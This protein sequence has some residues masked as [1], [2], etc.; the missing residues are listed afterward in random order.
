VSESTTY[1]VL[2]HRATGGRAPH[3]YQ[4]R[5]ATGTALPSVLLAPTG[6]GKTQAVVVA[7]LYRRLFAEPAVRA[8]TPRR[9]V[10]ALPMRV[11]VEQVW[12]VVNGLLD[13]L[14][15]DEVG[16]HL[17]IGG[18]GRPRDDWARHPERSALLVGTVD[19]LVSRALNRGYAAGRGRWPVDFGLLNADCLWVLDETQLMGAAV[20]TAAQLDGLRAKLGTFSACHTLWMS[21]TVDP[22][23]L[24]TVDRPATGDV[25]TLCAD[26]L[27]GELGRRL[28]APKRME[29]RDG[30]VAAIVAAEHAANS[31]T[32]A[33]HNTV[34]AAT[35]TYARLRRRP[36]AGEPEV[37]LLHSRF[38]P[39][40][41]ERLAARLAEPPPPGGRV[42]CATQ[43][44]E[45]GVDISA[46]LLV[47][48][49]APWSS[50]VQRLGRC[51]RYG[52]H[53]MGLVRWVEPKRPEPY[54]R[55]ELDHARAVL[56]RLEGEDASPQA[57]ADLHVEL[58]PAPLHPTLRRRDLL[59][60]F[61]TAPDLSGG[62][63][64]VSRFI[65][66]VEDVDCRVYWRT[67]DGDAPPPDLDAAR[68]EE[69]CPAPIGELRRF[70]D[71]RHGFTWDAVTSGWRR[72]RAAEL[73]PGAVVLLPAA[74]GGYTSE[75]GWDLA[76]KAPVEPLAGVAGPP[77][78]NRADPDAQIGAWVD[79]A[80]HTR[81]VEAEVGVIGAAALA[82]IPPEVAETLRLAARGHDVGKAFERWQAAVLTGA[83][84]RQG[85]IWAKTANRVA[86]GERN[87]RHELVSALALLRSGWLAER[88]ADPWAD[89][90]LFLVAAHHGKAR[91]TIRPWPDESDGAVLG[92]RDGDRL[93]AVTVDGLSLPN[94][95][96]DLRPLRMGDTDAGA[97]WASR[98]LRLRDHPALGPFRVAH[99]EA[100]L[101]AADWRAS[102]R[103]ERT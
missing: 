63:L 35:E 90:A 4:E 52:E 22:R 42:V 56:G 44:I 65:R 79:L 25:F 73:R 8:A 1:R 78:A 71:A 17:L 92:V 86:T 61:D 18:Q 27:A 72:V 39:P 7:W 100:L 99:L 85:T 82:G 13:A 59:D 60:L 47:T 62:D 58:L 102:E 93:P 29:H 69:L 55:A 14:G 38:R 91:V 40:D 49:L 3:P 24:V 51:N 45:A 84:D 96:L 6:S 48:E 26:D 54:D 53:E 37:R 94:V 103:E 43:V 89:L 64:D 46:R 41:R 16:R 15:L 101:R 88:L 66:D 80:T 32:L 23:T 36:P 34:K 30:D 83:T 21:A 68:A 31:L 81:D 10:Y 12:E 97:S 77:D 95:D 67:W 76:S 5:L 74:A 28:R 9:L 50:V 75:T 87:P 98:M 11:L 57:L 70:S 20:T 33:V 2:F 19:M